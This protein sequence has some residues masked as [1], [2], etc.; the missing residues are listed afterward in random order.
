VKF[1]A[2]LDSLPA[3]LEGRFPRYWLASNHPHS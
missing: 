3:A 2:G 1:G